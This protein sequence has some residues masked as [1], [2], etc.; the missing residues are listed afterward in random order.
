MGNRPVACVLLW[1]ALGGLAAAQVPPPESPFA[2]RSGAQLVNGKGCC[3]PLFADGPD[4]E[5][6]DGGLLPA[7]PEPRWTGGFELGVNGATGNTEVLNTRVFWNADRRTDTNLF[8]TDTTYLLGKQQGRT[9]QN[10][11]IINVRDEILIRNTP[12]SIY[13]LGFFDY[14]ELRD[15]RFILGLYGGAGLLVVDND[16]LFLKLRG[17]AGAIYRTGG[18]DDRWEPS[19]NFGWDQRYQF[20]ER[21]SIISNLDYYPAFADFGD[22]LLRL[23]IAYE[24]TL[25]PESGFFFRTGIFERYDSRPGP[26]VK[27]SDLNY[28]MS[29]G[30]NF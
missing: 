5:A 6:P 20:T 11:A 8:H 26:G 13:G 27:K 10:T 23:R 15:Y 9:I 12:W 30:F 21:S 22:F 14:D 2:G 4:P 17:G 19:L 16:K 29:L 18:P 28:F 24:V 25:D 7:P 3:K 1:I